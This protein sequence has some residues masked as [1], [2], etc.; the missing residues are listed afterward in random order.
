MRLE[1]TFTE[2]GVP[3]AYEKVIDLR[4][5]YSRAV[6]SSGPVRQITGYDGVAWNSNNGIVNS[7]D[8]PTLVQDAHS[9]AFVDAAWWRQALARKWITRVGNPSDSTGPSIA[10]TPDSGS[11]LVLVF[12]PK[13]HFVRRIDFDADEGP[14]VTTLSD[15]RQAGPIKYPFR[16]EQK[17]ATG[18]AIVVQY[19]RVQLL[20]S[21]DAG[22]FAR[23]PAAP[24]AHL[25]GA[26]PSTVPFTF[27]GA[28]QNHI[29]VK[30]TVDGTET[31]LNFDTGGANY[32]SPAAAQRF[33]LQIFGGLN[34][35][36][37]G[38]S[39]TTGGFARVKRMAIGDAELSDETVIIA[40]LP[41]PNTGSG[42]RVEGTAGFEYLY[43]FR[44]TIDYAA[45]TMTF[46]SAATPEVVPG[47]KVP[48]F[49]DGHSI[50]VEA[51]VEGRRG[52]FR[53]DTGDGGTVTLF[54]AFAARHGL[55]QGSGPAQ[56][57]GGGVG[58]QVSARPIVISRF[59]LGGVVFDSLKG[60][61][62]LNRAGS[63]SSRALAG[64]LGGGVLK[65]FR[66]TFDYPGRVLTMEAVGGAP[67]CP[68][69]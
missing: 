57:S 46:A 58:G 59:A 32:F 68:P 13:T 21:V 22:L 63:F 48:F 25:A 52:V 9:R 31:I 35:T 69:K 60:N 28:R 39:G 43:E 40:P 45:R 36:G 11:E 29:M 3:A 15:W 1:G 20:S 55:F 4:T 65:C 67:G 49:S 18:S 16:Q 62:S 66:I 37:V 38:E 54:P 5:G 47:A 2:G 44:T 27:A 51:E 34:V 23:P 17:D 6:Q 10:F 50:Y 19:Q 26:A 42:P 12:D 7:V 41:W 24:R 30:A 33:G 14:L 53:L 56:V 61:L 64:N 8:L